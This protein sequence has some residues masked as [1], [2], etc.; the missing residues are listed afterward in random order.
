GA[1][2]ID[3]LNECRWNAAAGVP[4]C[5]P[6]VEAVDCRR[7]IAAPLERLKVAPSA[8]GSTIAAAAIAAAKAHYWKARCSRRIPL[9]VAHD[10]CCRVPTGA[11]LELRDAHRRGTAARVAT[12][13][14]G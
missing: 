3:R 9:H 10:R 1:A 8:P 2:T 13:R 6:L 11:V 5:A 7:A 14:A 4:D 12:H